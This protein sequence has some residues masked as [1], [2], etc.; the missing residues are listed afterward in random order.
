[1]GEI[2]THLERLAFRAKDPQTPSSELELEYRKILAKHPEIREVY[3]RL[4][5]ILVKQNKLSQALEIFEQALTLNPTS[6]VIKS[7][8][9]MVYG[10]LGRF[11][12]GIAIL[13]LILEQ[14]PDDN[15]LENSF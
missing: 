7:N 14:V 8:I 3:L 9:A 6:T 2:I 4:G 10:S 11:S 5:Q 13:E 12:D 1:M 15:L